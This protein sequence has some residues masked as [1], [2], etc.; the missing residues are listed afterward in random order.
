MGEEE[1]CLTFGAVYHSPYTADVDR[2]IDSQSTSN[3]SGSISTFSNHI[4]EHFE[5]DYPM[6]IGAGWG[7]RYSDALSLSMD[8]TWT[9]WSE[10]EQENKETGE[11]TRPLG[12]GVSTDRDI[13][14]TYAVRF[15]TEYLIFRQKMIIPV[16]GGLFYEPRP[17]L[18]DP[19]DVY[20][21]S[22]GSGITFKRFSIDGAYQF[23]WAND[24]DG[25]DFW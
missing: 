3:F 16:R 15:G 14:D 2:I 13:D 20:G 4:R 19:T 6:S 7:F 9:D 18:D 11:E 25:E 21:V 5:I 1:K 17:S 12:L 23:R 8:V 10:Y 22:V 24:V